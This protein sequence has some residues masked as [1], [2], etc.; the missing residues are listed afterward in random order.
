MTV[1]LSA[2]LRSLALAVAVILLGACAANKH[3]EEANR[4]IAAGR[5]EAALAELERAVKQEPRNA[6]Y[7]STLLR[8]RNRVAT[9]RLVEGDSLAREERFDDAETA[10]RAALAAEPDNQRVPVRLAEL[11]KARQ[12]RVMLQEAREAFKANRL[13]DAESRLRTLLQNTPNYPGARDLLRRVTE[14]ASIVP[15]PS[16]KAPFAKPITLEFRDAA[17][18]TVFDMLSR[19]S[20]INFVFDRDVRQDTKLTVFVRN[21]TLEDALKL[22]LTTNQLDHKVLNENSVLVYPNTPAKQKDYR[23]LVVRSYYISNADV[24]QAA[25]LVKSIVKTQ[26]VF[27]DE[28]LN[29]MVVKDTPDVIRLADQLVRTLDVA[30]PEVMLDVE[31]MEVARTRAENLGIQFPGS[32][33][34]GARPAT[35]TTTS[36]AATTT[37]IDAPMFFSTSNPAIVF[38]LR[39]T[40]GSTNLLANPRIRVKNK[41]KAKIHIGDKVPVFTSTAA[42]LTVATSVSYLDVGLKLDVEPQ[43]YLS[44]DVQIKVALEVSNIV[45]RVEVGSATSPTVAFRIGT[46]NA[47]TVLQLRDGETQILAGLINDEDRRSSTR[48]PGLGDIPMLSRIFGSSTDTKVKNEIVLLITPRIVRNINRPDGLDAEMAVGTDTAPGMPPLRIAKTAPG[49][50]A[51]SPAG[52]NGG[53]PADAPPA[54][55]SANVPVELNAALRLQAPAQARVGG[56]ISVRLQAPAGLE[57]KDGFV[58]LSFDPAALAPVG[59]AAPVPGRVQID[60]STVAS[61]AEL[62]F[63]VLGDKAGTTQVA[64][65]NIELVD[66]SG[67]AVGMMAPPPAQIAI[68]K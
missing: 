34:L 43:I 42:N 6:Q 39:A 46:R 12:S 47:N 18:R 51:V 56:E 31:V 8:E 10:Y 7:R 5:P 44:D 41:E 28:K 55:P 45:E 33:S 58:E 27:I 20:G 61:G 62:R 17:M 15:A 29:L 11:A 60:S 65:S 22:I 38:N 9:M 26:D 66:A 35:T 16:L 63:K 50:L 67:F 59:F 24:K 4:L 30:D 37:A 64:V 68:V 21:V 14:A 19:T 1:A 40:V 25:A 13:P 36:T 49:S 2:S 53:G 23:E 3:Y 48:I 32:V 54:P 52:A 57:L